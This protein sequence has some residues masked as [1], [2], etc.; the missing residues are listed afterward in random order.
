MESILRY[1]KIFYEK[2][3]RN[4]NTERYW[5]FLKYCS[6]SIKPEYTE[7]HHMLP[8]SLFD[9]Y[10]NEKENLIVLSAREHFLAHWM[11]ARALH[12]KMWYA[13]N[14]MFRVIP[15]NKRNSRLYDKARQYIA[16]VISETNTGSTMSEENRKMMSIR[17]RGTVNVVDSEG[18]GF[19]V[20]VDDPRI[21]TGELVYPMVGKTHSDE[22]KKLMS[23][24]GIKGR[25][26][27]TNIHTNKLTYI[28][29]NV[30]EY[31]VDDDY[32]LGLPEEMCEVLSNRVKD[33]QWYNNGVDD[34][35]LTPNEYKEYKSTNGELKR[36]RLKFNN[37]GFDFINSKDVIHVTDLRNMRCEYLSCKSEIKKYHAKAINDKDSVIYTFDDKIITTHSALKVYLKTIGIFLPNGGKKEFLN[38]KVSKPHHNM[39]K[40]K[41][42]FCEK[43]QGYRLTDL[44]LTVYN[45]SEFNYF[46]HEDKEIFWLET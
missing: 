38:N 39:S 44:G 41:Y 23:Q 16:K 2:F 12:G 33:K 14:L 8:R 42:N 7:R 26:A 46:E 13:F 11:L 4:H 28:K 24:N 10:K 40:E 5:N 35:R 30:L 25:I 34:I 9:E 3:E 18:N 6:T 1:E 37:R 19:R 22:T 20:D 43:Y 36:G 45:I 29:E 15:E 31:M 21:K 32:I 27:F 17:H